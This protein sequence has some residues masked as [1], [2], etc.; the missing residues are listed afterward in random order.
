MDI[1]LNLVDFTAKSG[2]FHAKSGG[3]DTL[4]ERHHLARERTLVLTN[5]SERYLQ[6]FNTKFT[7]LNTKF[8]VVTSRD[9]PECS[10][11]K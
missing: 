6:D 7:I 4:P 5:L 10:E 8:I 11:W 9:W 2:G 1:L 3:V